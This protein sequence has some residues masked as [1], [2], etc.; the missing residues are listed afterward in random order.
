MSDDRDIVVDL[1]EA[2]AETGAAPETVKTTPTDV[3]EA[4]DDR[5]LPR[6][7][8]KNADGSVTV[9][10]DHPKAVTIRT[11]QGAVRAETYRELTFHRLTGADL[12]AIRATAREHQ[13]L[14][15]F[16]RSSRIRTAVMSALY[17]KLDAADITRCGRVIDTFL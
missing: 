17:P 8:V 7:A 5:V 16:T 14:V 4:D 3:D 12:S 10:L 1:D 6:G 11:A 15:L 2:A 9:T 13:D